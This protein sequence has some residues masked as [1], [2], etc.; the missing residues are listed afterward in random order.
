RSEPAIRHRKRFGRGHQELQEGIEGRAQRARAAE[1]DQSGRERQEGV[2][3]TS[4]ALADRDRFPYVE[5]PQ[6]GRRPRRV[7]P[8]NGRKTPRI[9]ALQATLHVD[10]TGGPLVEAR[11]PRG[12][13]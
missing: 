9:C 11:C 6:A 3:R 1:A 7:T 13:P 8:P 2:E 12:E 5:S 4:S 10:G